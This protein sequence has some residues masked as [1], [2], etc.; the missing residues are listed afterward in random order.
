MAHDRAD[1]DVVM[2]SIRSSKLAVADRVYREMEA[3]AEKRAQMAADM[4]GVP[5]SEMS[6][7]KITNMRDNQRPGDIPVPQR[8]VPGAVYDPSAGA[9][10]ASSIRSGPF[11]NRGMKVLDVARTVHEEG[12]NMVSRPV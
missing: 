4:F 2:P 5:V 10:Y 8:T 9:Q 7:L 12:N 6:E 11:P 3:G 1:D